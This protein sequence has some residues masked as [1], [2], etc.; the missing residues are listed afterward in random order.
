MIDWAAVSNSV[1]PTPSTNA[2]MYMTG[3]PTMPIAIPIASPPAITARSTATLTMVR[4]RSR[5]SARA[6]AMRT[7]TSQGSRPTTVMP[8]TR[9]GESVRRTASSG[10]AIQKTPS[11]RFE[12]A[13]EPQS[14][15]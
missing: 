4:R 8:A 14:F 3:R 10:N 2:A 9:A 13:D 7:N 12:V 5:R 15:Q 11:A 1:S 6:P